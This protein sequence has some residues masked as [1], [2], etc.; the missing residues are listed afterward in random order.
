MW[1]T[2]ESDA[3]GLTSLAGRWQEGLRVLLAALLAGGGLG[4][5]ALFQ[6]RGL[7]SPVVMEQAEIARNLASG[8]GFVTQVVRP[9][10]LWLLQR[11]AGD[12]SGP[13]AALWQAPLYPHLLATVF[14]L[15]PPEFSFSR[16][17]YLDAETQVIVPLSLLLVLL[18]AIVLWCLTRDVFDRTTAGWTALVFLVSPLSLRLVLEGGALPLAMLGCV[19]CIWL[20]W[21]AFASSMFGASPGKDLL[22]A[23]G[24]GVFAGLAVLTHYTALL[25]LAGCAVLLVFQLRR[26]RWLSVALYCLLALVVLVPWVVAHREAGWWGFMAYPYA[27]L[28]DTVTFRGDHLLRDPAPILRSWLVTQAIRDGIAT[29]YTE[30]LQGRMLAAAGFSVVFFLAGLFRREEHDWH[31]S[32]KWGLAVLFC[33]LPLLPQ[34]SGSA[35]SPVAL[36]FPFMVMYGVHAFLRLLDAQ[37][38]FDPAIRPLC[39]GLFVGLCMLP[40]LTGILQRNPAAPYPPYHGPLQRYATSWVADGSILVTDI[41]WATAWYGGRTSLLYPREAAMVAAYGDPVDAIYLAGKSD[42]DTPEDVAWER[43]RQDGIVPE[44]LPFTA[45]LFLPAETRDQILILRESPVP[46]DTSSP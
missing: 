28:V 38:F 34:V 39:L 42:G 7:R 27:A 14:R 24:A 35:A 32:G 1:Q 44:M 43:M 6:F 20:A 3:G 12:A 19:L 45:G 25:M 26:L 37:D 11:P 23:G 18:T 17:G 8:Q 36:L 41:P 4:L 10:D 46:V 16:R 31:Q 2:R 5:Y 33:L 40:A 21:K 15:V 29:R 9:F 30:W 22:W 13:I